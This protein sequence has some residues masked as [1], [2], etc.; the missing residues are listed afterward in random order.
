MIVETGRLRLSRDARLLLVAR[1]LRAF[2]DGLVSIALPL[3]LVARGFSPLQIGALVTATLL[4]SAAVTLGVG[5]WGHDWPAT[6]LLRWV[7]VAMAGTGALFSLFESYVPLL[8][9]ATI[10]TLN[11]SS[12]DVSVFLPTEQALLPATAPDRH[13]T[14]LFA[15]YSFVGFFLAALG[16]LAAALPETIGGAAGWSVAASLRVTFGVYAA[17]GIV[18]WITYGRL[19]PT[20]GQPD[21]QPDPDPDSAGV[22]GRSRRF[23]ALGPSKAVVYR[24]AALF[25]LDAFGGGFVVQSILVLWLTQR[26][27]FSA[28]TAGVLFFWAGVASAASALA[29]PRLARRIGLIRTMAFTHLPANVFLMAAAV[30]PNATSAVVFLLARALL[31]QMDVPARTSYV[32]AVVTA[33]ERPAAAS[34]TNVPR[35][36]AAAATPLAA[37]WLLSRT[38]FG[39][40]LVLGGALKVV[41]DLLLLWMFHDVRPPEERAAG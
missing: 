38:S 6:A 15:R 14:A 19:S 24:L 7:A 37:G 20:M 30:M 4:G 9:V 3:Y 5:V 27:G 10:G 22:A 8:V 1:G 39:W 25:S 17:V 11:P 41:Y 33:A 13:R 32:M 36:L 12:G 21:P 18:V 28:T 26:H 23:G 29:A 31:S 40:P 2:T 16:S 34:L 35:S